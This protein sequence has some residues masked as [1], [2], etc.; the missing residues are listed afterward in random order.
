MVTIKKI[1]REYEIKRNEYTGLEY[2]KYLESEEEYIRRVE[3][4][5]NTIGE[6]ISAQFFMRNLHVDTCI[7]TYKNK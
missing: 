7:I 4:L 6:V 2:I 3:N 5:C 1:I